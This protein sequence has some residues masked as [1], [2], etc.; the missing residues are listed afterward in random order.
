MAAKVG[1][2]KSYVESNT[3]TGMSEYDREQRTAYLNGIW[4]YW[5]HEIAESRKVKAE[6]LDQ[7]ANDSILMLADN[8]DYVASKLID[9]VLFP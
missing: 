9:K 8:K 7:L 6:Q 4:Q 3:L 2:Y 1:K 5:L